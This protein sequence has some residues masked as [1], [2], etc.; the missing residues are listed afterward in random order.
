MI[1]LSFLL[2]IFGNNKYKNE[3]IN[4]MKVKRLN[5]ERIPY[6]VKED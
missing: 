3:N 1:Y 6:D 4:Y 2:F 5:E